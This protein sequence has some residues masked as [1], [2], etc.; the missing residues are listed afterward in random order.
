MKFIDSH[1]H[2][3]FTEFDAERESLIKACV[4]KGVER[5]IVPGISL[6]QSKQ[7]IEFKSKYSHVHMAA[8]LHP[9]F[10]ADHK[11]THLAQLFDF[12]NANINQLVAIGECGLDRSIEDLTKQTWLF[13]QQI[14]L[15]N[16]LNLPL[17]IHHRQSHDLIAQ[18]F[19][20]CKPKYGGVIHAFS[21]S[22]Q[23]AHYYIKQGFKL[24]VG[25]I[26]TYERALKTRNVIA[27]I[28]PQHLVLETDSPSMPL[29]GHQGEINTPLHIPNVFNVLCG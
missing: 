11:E 10:L 9:Y 5:F 19:K 28:E 23:Q 27:Q 25:G 16:E 17:I 20:R 18:S 22:L 21:G 12:A 8:G 4:A 13:E 6:A 15:A 24:G 7:L 29:S 3:D 14:T 26:I 2:L 1:C